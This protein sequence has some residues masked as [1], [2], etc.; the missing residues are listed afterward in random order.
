[1]RWLRYALAGLTLMGTV[2]AQGAELPFA[3]AEA[4]RQV[5]DREQWLDGTVEAVNQATITAQTSGQVAEIYFDIGERVPPGSVVMRLRGREQRA[6]VEEASARFDQAESD[7]NR[8][9][10]VYERQLVS[11]AEFD[12]A[13]ANYRAAKAALERAREQA[14][15]TEVRAPYGGVVTKR[16][17]EVGDVAQLGQPLISGV[18]LDRLRVVVEVPERLL[19]AVRRESR[20]RVQLGGEPSEVIVDKFTVFPYADST[21]NTVRVRLRLPDGIGADGEGHDLL[22]G[23]MVKVAFATGTREQLVVPTAAVVQRSEVSG[24]YVVRDDGTVALRQVRLGNTQGEVT[25]ILAGLQAGER[26]ATDPIRA[27][28][29]V[30]EQQAAGAT[31]E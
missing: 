6:V 25:E 22:P 13:E 24:V 4:V 17:V 12:R 3:T 21:S 10:D 30:K 27:G 5:V 19:D 8:I 16:H 15:Y 31:H 1:M 20:A 29:Y 23:M 14:G 11:K 9:K 7:F 2:T 18:S 28:A 26:V